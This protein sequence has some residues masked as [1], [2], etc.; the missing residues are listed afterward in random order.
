MKN[1]HTKWLGKECVHKEIT[2]STSNDISRMALE[3]A[4]E[5]TIVTADVQTAGKGRRGRSWESQNGTSLLFSILLRPEMEPDKAPQITLL[6]A[7]AVARV[8]FEWMH[9]EARIKWPNDVVVNKKKVCG[10]LTEMQLKG[11]AIDFVVV[12]TGVNVNQKSIPE[13][14]QESA[15]SLLLEKNRLASMVENIDKQFVHEVQMIENLTEEDVPDFERNFELECID[16]ETLLE[17]ILQAFEEYYEIFLRTRD[18]SG[19]MEEYN[20]RLVS[21]DKE[22]KVLDPKGEFTGVSKGINGK[23]ELLVELPSGEVTAIYA[24]EVSVRGLYGYV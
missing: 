18:L 20:G 24:G 11:S 15:T 13:E 1:F 19:L 6:M 22:V 7:M 17:L 14:L 21:L 3:G 23:G 10:I 16:R 12:G 8:V 4:P 9:L 5:G 2:D